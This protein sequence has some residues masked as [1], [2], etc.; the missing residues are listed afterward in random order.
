MGML[1]DE[2]LVE[3]YRAASGS[4]RETRIVSRRTQFRDR[5][6]ERHRRLVD[7]PAPL[8][9]ERFLKPRSFSAYFARDQDEQRGNYRPIGHIVYPILCLA[10]ETLA[11]IL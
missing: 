11:E 6:V 7:F 1:S 4:S 10:Q 2:E 9:F 8:Q 5:N 3:R